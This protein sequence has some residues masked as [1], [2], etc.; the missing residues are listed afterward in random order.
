MSR[1]RSDHGKVLFEPDWAQGS[2]FEGLRARRDFSRRVQSVPFRVYEKGFTHSTVE[3]SEE[4]GV[5]DHFVPTESLKRVSVVPEDDP[6]N[7]K[8]IYTRQGEEVELR[9]DPEELD[10]PLGA[11]LALKAIA[12]A[13][14]DKSATAL[15]NPERVLGRTP[16]SEVYECKLDME[17]TCPLDEGRP[18]SITQSD[19]C[20][21]RYRTSVFSPGFG[22]VLEGTVS[23]C[24]IL[25]FGSI[26]LFTTFLLLI[27]IIRNPTIPTDPLTEASVY[28]YASP[29]LFAFLLYY[30]VRLLKKSYRDAW[31]SFTCAPVPGGVFV[32]ITLAHRLLLRTGPVVPLS[33]IKRA[34]LRLWAYFAGHFYYLFT[35]GG[36]RIHIKGPLFSAL[37]GAEGFE[38]TNFA[39]VNAR[40]EKGP[41]RAL[42]SVDWT[43]VVT[44]FAGCALALLLSFTLSI[45]LFVFV[46]VLNVLLLFVP[47]LVAD[48]RMRH[49]EH[50]SHGLR[51][52]E[53]SI[54][55]P[56]AKGG[57]RYI[58]WPDVRSA[59]VVRWGGSLAVA[60]A[61][62][63]GTVH[64]PVSATEQMRAQDREVLDPT[65]LLAGSG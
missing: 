2:G 63:D 50:L 22:D 58:R 54:S 45:A 5:E 52:N 19:E 59:T 37:Q 15:L 18:C 7:V 48:V 42:A 8:L 62:A 6:E 4:T 49:V 34:E 30:L 28:F 55:V 56:L 10:N 60:V 44:L 35:V 14:I 39:A 23:V 61:T 36:E 40:A 11:I 64:L 20:G 29:L 9:L 27:S 41:Q 31:F 21:E 43:T 24:L 32:P 46:L 1:M 47:L 13:T 17:G 26:F 12:P 57:S 33:S 25:V 16:P 51:V 3:P 53:G 65:G 38:R